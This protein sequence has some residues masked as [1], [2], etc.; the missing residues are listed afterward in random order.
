VSRKAAIV[1]SSTDEKI[2]ENLTIFETVA[3]N[4]GLPYRTFIDMDKALTWLL[5]DDRT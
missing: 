5:G 2:N 4:R 1:Y 3:R